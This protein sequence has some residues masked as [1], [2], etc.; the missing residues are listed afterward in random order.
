LRTILAFLFFLLLLTRHPSC[1]S[2]GSLDSIAIYWILG[3]GQEKH[4]FIA[5]INLEN[6]IN[7]D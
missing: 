3:R 1:R 7:T 6:K 2:A 5:K 4:E